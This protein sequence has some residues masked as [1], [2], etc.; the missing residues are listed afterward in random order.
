MKKWLLGVGI[1]LAV[2]LAAVGFQAS[3]NLR[4]RNPGYELDLTIAASTPTRLKVGFAAVP[5]SPPLEDTWTDANN[6]ARYNPSDG[7]TYTD[8][9]G[10]GQFDPYWIAG[11]ST[12]RAATGIHDDLWARVMVIDDSRTRIAIVSLDA[13]GFFHDNVVAVRKRVAE[14]CRVDYT[15]ISSTHV[16]EAPDLMGLWGPSHLQT[17]INPDYRDL[18]IEQTAQAVFAAVEGLTPA[19]LRITQDL[20]G[21]T[22]LVNDSRRPKVLD[23]G[24]R[25]I[26]AVEPE[27]GRSIGVLVSWADHPETTWSKNLLITSDY[28]HY[29]R[30]ALED[31]LYSNENKVREGLGGTAVFVN[32]A[33]GGLMTT[34]PEL[35]IRDPISGE[36]F[37]EPSFEKIRAQGY[38]LAELVLDALS[39]DQVTEIHEASL[40]VRAKTIP[41]PIENPILQFGAA[42]GV[43][44][45]GFIG[46]STL[47]TEVAAFTLGEISF[48]TVPGE[49]YPEIIEGGIESPP[50]QDFL[51]EPVEIPPVREKMPGRYRFVL[52]LAND[53]IGYIIPKSEWDEDAPYLY[54]A[55]ESPY[56]EINSPGPE[57]GP[58]LHREILSLLEELLQLSG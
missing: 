12:G 56:G 9:N 11:F 5:I 38:Q 46:W 33:I 22:K 47:R 6:D 58:I 28:P 7:D 53:E 32:G 52:G 39:S 15:V 1:G 16:H 43:I 57:T 34:D 40:A 23:P 26:Q 55:E 48:I 35:G 49:I 51:I 42:I 45:R 31:G 2:L 13:I 50:G 41:F 37:T 29:L 27:S 54:N 20:T 25:I 44:D 24:L 19:F 17:G 21:A 4:D 8:T 10:N 36:T 18:V 3:S 30:E 14:L